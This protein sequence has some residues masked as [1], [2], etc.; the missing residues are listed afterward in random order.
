MSLDEKVTRMQCIDCRRR[1]A[2][3]RSAD[4]RNPQVCTEC[5]KGAPYNLVRDDAGIP[6]AEDTLRSAMGMT[7]EES[8][9]YNDEG[10]PMDPE[11]QAYYDRMAAAVK[12]E[13]LRI[14]IKH[15]VEGPSGDPYSWTEYRITLPG[16]EKVMLR[17]AEFSPKLEIEGMDI[18]HDSSTFGLLFEEYIGFGIDQ[19]HF[20]HSAEYERDSDIRQAEL[21]AGWDASP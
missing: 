13:G 16:G 7:Q 20:W 21:S 1:L 9:E 10:P 8:E 12:P 19:I 17:D 18:P 15:G 14:E 6:L 11:E 3:E 5:R 4:G 2:H